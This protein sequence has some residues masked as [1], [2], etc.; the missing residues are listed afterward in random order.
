MESG[1]TLCYTA[2]VM[3][4][5]E[6]EIRARLQELPGWNFVDGKISRDYVF[7][8][9]VEAFAAMTA[10]AVKAEALNHHPD[11]TNSY[12]KLKISLSTHDAGGVTELD[13]TLAREI[14][15]IV[16]RE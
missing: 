9:F 8:N 7:A 16:A 10:I 13:F 3:P 12:N 14:E 11:W 5:S 1:L 6:Q 2:Y 4:L 15:A